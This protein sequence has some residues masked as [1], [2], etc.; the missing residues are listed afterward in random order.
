MSAHFVKAA[1]FTMVEMAL[2]NTRKI[3]HYMTVP[4][5]HGSLK[6]MCIP[7]SPAFVSINEAIYIKN[8]LFR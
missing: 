8:D 2:I 5:H 7:E 1:I 4:G 6:S 3:F